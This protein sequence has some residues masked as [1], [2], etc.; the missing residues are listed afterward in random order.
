[1]RIW[2]LPLLVTSALAQVSPTRNSATVPLALDHNRVV[3]EAG[4]TLPDGSTAQIK[5]WVN[6]GDPELALSRRV[7]TLLGLKVTCGDQSCSAPPPAEISI[8]GMKVPLNT[9]KEATIALKPVSTAV[10]VFSGMAAEMNIPSTV[11]RNYDVLIDFPGRRFTIARP[12]GIAFEGVKAKVITNP[13]S[14]LIQVP[15]QIEKKRFNLGLDLGSSITFLDPSLFDG[16]TAAHP[17]WPHMTG[18][19]GP[20]NSRG[21]ATELAA[22]LMRVERLQFGPLFL[23]DVAAERLPGAVGTDKAGVLGADALL[24]YRVGFDYAR[25]VVYFD[26]GRLFKFPEFDVIGLIVRPEDDGK[27][28]VLGV[29]DYDAKPSL[30]TGPNGVEAG[31]RVIAVDGISTDGATMG[32]FWLMLGGAPGQQRRITLERAGKQFTIMATVR[33]FLAPTSAD[34]EDAPQK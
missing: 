1:M 13:V 17:Q 34:G 23:T 12:G 14:G 21:S 25:S 20:A 33:H 22:K 10:V 8:G 27:F 6:N 28:T 30:Q 18:G 5:A 32:G 16:L 26:I 29:A 15:S 3:I 19:V 4:V 24:N 7:A 9:V 11:L 31:D 2:I